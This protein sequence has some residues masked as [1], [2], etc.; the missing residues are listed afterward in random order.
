M[1]ELNPMSFSQ[2]QRMEIMKAVVD[3]ETLLYM[4]NVFHEDVHPRNVL[5]L[6]SVETPKGMRIVV[7][8]FAKSSTERTPLPKAEV[9]DLLPGVPISPLLRW[10]EVWG[11]W[12]QFEA[13]VDWDWQLWLESQYAWTRSSITDYMRSIWL[14]S[15]MFKPLVEPPAW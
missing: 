12:N 10:H 5:L 11:K 2:S 6:D 9:R 13:W 14:P 8:D 7:I 1:Q 15:T 4:Y 3:T